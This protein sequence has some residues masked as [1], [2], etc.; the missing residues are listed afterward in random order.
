MIDQELVYLVDD[1]PAVLRALG[2]LLGTEGLMVEAFASAEEFLL[3]QDPDQPGCVV[4]DLRLPKMDGLAMQQALLTAGGARVVV[5]M[6]AYGDIATGVRAMKAGAVDFLVKP[7]DGE[8]FLAAVRC[9]LAKDRQAR[10]VQMELQLVRGRMATL[11]P[12]EHQVL[13]HVVFGR[14]NKQIAA[15]LG[16]TEKT[17][18]V[19]RA[20][21]MEK[22]GVRTLAEL[23]RKT[24][25]VEVGF[26]VDDHRYHGRGHG[27]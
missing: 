26:V 11:T 17:I 8:V 4:A 7:F 1:D 5:L 15:D 22:M 13:G 21:A 10:Q 9:A 6:S 12:R 19:H 14:L 20:R 16:I 3:A 25:E 18:K 23:V 27:L 2:R 24:L